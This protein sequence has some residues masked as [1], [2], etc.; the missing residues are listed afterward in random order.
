MSKANYLRTP[1]HLDAGGTLA[2]AHVGIWLNHMAL[3][4]QYHGNPCPA[5]L[6]VCP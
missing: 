5:R 6:V 2:G 1:V 4:T 3:N